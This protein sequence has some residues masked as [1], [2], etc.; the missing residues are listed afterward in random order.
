M[1]AITQLT[2]TV[3]SLCIAIVG[4]ALAKS[5]TEPTDCVVAI[6]PASSTFGEEGGNGSVTVT[7]GA[8]CTWSAT[9]SADWI[10]MTGGTGAGPR[11]LAYA[12]AANAATES[13]TGTLTIAGQRHT[14]TQSGR[15]PA[16]CSYA[17]APA[18]LDFGP[19]GGTGTVTVT[20]A[21]GCTWSAVPRAEWVAITS[22]R[23]GEGP[24]TIT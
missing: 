2:A 5:P 10:M 16:T 23:A 22:G 8:G 6:A 14:V 1:K 19:D 13:R 12:V 18:S 9:A 4:C 24:G 11:T 7:T 20:T 15:A 21:P 17:I 3:A